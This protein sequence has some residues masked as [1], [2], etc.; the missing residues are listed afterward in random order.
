M[1]HLFVYG[2]LRSA[3]P[4]EFARL[5]AEHEILL[6][7]ARIQGRLYHLGRFPGLVLSDAAGEW[8]IGELYRFRDGSSTLAA[9]DRYEGPDFT[10]EAAAALLETGER[11]PAWVYV[12]NRPVPEQSRILS[13]DYLM[14][15]SYP[16]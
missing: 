4:N 3:L 12:Y 7:P 14:A 10:R 9:L 5:L 8:V 2:T 11:L 6:G 1:H 13:G 16:C 15:T